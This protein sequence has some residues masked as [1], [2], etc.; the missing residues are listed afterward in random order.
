VITSQ[1]LADK[2]GI[3]QRTV[4]RDIKALEEAGVPI[5]GEIGTGYS[6]AGGYRMPPL[7]FSE[8]ELNALLTAQQLLLKNTDKSICKE[9]E[10]I[11]TKIKAIIRYSEK[12]KLEK[13]ENRIRVFSNDT[14]TQTTMLSSIQLAISHCSKIKIKYHTIHSDQINDRIVQPLAMYFTKGNW[15]LIGFC[16]LR[17]E[18]RDFRLDRIL[19]LHTTTETFPDTNFNIDDY[20]KPRWEHLQ[21]RTD[22]PL[23]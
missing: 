5:I 6:L 21:N 4:Y 12:E 19:N 2:F 14:Q 7:M 8:N 11:V 20:F 22:I 1:E 16:E 3:S 9:L 15:I 23:S 18:N 13:L 10:N 17:K